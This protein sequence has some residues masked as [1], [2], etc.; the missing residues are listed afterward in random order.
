[1][2]ADRQVGA[3]RRWAFR[4]V[5]VARAA[6]LR[7]AIYLVTVLD[8]LF[9]VTDPIDHGDV[10]AALY[11]PLPVRDL[12]HLPQP[13]PLYTRVLLVVILVSALVAAAGRFPRVAG[14][15][16]AL[17][18]LDWVS[19]GMSYGKVDHDHFALVV[20]LFV[21]PSVGRAGWSDL[22]HSEAAGWALRLV[23]VAV[24]ATYFLSAVA[25]VREGGWL[26][27]SSAT[28]LW[29]LSRRGAVQPA[30]WLSTQLLIT[31]LMQ[32]VVFCMEL[33]TPLMLWLRG[34]ALHLVVVFW[35]LFH[36]S[37]YALLTIH[38]LPTAVCLLAFLP[39]ERARLRRRSATSAGVEPAVEEARP[40]RRAR[41]VGT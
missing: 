40:V 14:W 11:Q 26:W 18:M 9:F 3:L 21:L 1:M 39:L 17:A 8:V 36:A 2:S 10:P 29:A 30:Q 15:V 24:V 12:L 37:T 13:S 25:K 27:G 6:R 28:L 33:L 32:W 34:R 38:F 35:V 5:P 16:C 31:Q 20:A 4:P 23:Q 19:N 7:A 22:R 41:P